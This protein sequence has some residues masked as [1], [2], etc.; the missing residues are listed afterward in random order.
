MVDFLAVM[1]SYMEAKQ[2]FI[3]ELT[4]DAEAHEAERYNDIAVDLSLV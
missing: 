2:I 4:Q 1:L 3:T